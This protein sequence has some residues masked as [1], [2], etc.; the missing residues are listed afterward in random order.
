QFAKPRFVGVAVS[1][2]QHT[3]AFT[4]NQ[5]IAAFNG[6]AVARE[7]NDLGEL[8]SEGGESGDFRLAVLIPKASH[9]EPVADGEELGAIAVADSVLLLFLVLPIGLADG[10]QILAA[11]RAGQKRPEAAGAL[12]NQ[13]LVLILIICIASTGALK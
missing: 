3:P 10:I 8:L 2:D 9:H 6:G 5:H 4:E 11:R 7:V 1:P 13:G 12:F